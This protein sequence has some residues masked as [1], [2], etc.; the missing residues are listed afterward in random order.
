MENYFFLFYHLENHGIF[1]NLIKLLNILV[2]QIIYKKMK[3]INSIIKLS[4]KSFFVILI[5][6]ILKFRNIDLLHFIVPNFDPHPIIHEIE[7][8]WIGTCIVTF[9]MKLSFTNSQW[10][11]YV[12]QSWLPHKGRLL[13]R[14]LNSFVYNIL[15]QSKKSRRVDVIGGCP[16][17]TSP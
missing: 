1:H 15:E 13:I 6:A 17:M 8:M 11:N 2:V 5:F 4:N 9:F 14:G 16:L 12:N 7:S 3:K 10:E